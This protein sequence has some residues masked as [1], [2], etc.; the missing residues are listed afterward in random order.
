MTDSTG[1]LATTDV[2]RE[3]LG[4]G[5]A[6]ATF[7]ELLQGRLPSGERDFLVTLPIDR[8][9]TADFQWRPDQPLAVEPPGKVKSWKLAKRILRL[10]GISGGGLLTIRSDLPEGKGLASS[11]ADLVATARAIGHRF[12]ISMPAELI[13]SL[14][15]PIE[16]TDG[17]MHDGVTAFYHREVRL[18]ARL[19]H[20]PPLTV[21][22][23]DEGGEIDTIHFNQ[24]LKKFGR[25]DMHEY[26]R[27]LTVLSQAVRDGDAAAIGQVA[28]R[29]ALMNQRRHEKRLLPDLLGI[30]ASLGGLGVVAAHSGT[31]L[32]IIL[33]TPNPHHTER[34]DKVTAACFELAGNVDINRALKPP[35]ARTPSPPVLD[36]SSPSRGENLLVL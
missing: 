18:C 12:G 35:G 9:S 29:S 26:G 7:G 25:E 28:T 23:V 20:L 6:N 8:W 14:I 1:P 21:V 3:T 13:E 24:R 4:Q 34:L 11:S 36:H 10:Y 17:V 5:T 31:T 30:C 19:G 22:G 27:L 15:R 33:H 2:A 16:P 32:G